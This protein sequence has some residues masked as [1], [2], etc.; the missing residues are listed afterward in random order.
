VRGRVGQQVLLGL[1]PLVL[2]RPLQGG[3]VDLGRLVP[4]EVEL[5]GPG[6]L[7][8]AQRGE[9]VDHVGHVVAGGPQRVEVDAAEAVERLRAGPPGGAGLVRVL[10]VQVHQG[11]AEHG[12]LARVAS[13]PSM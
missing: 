5:P 9:L 11:G 10:A 7:V 3:A 4:H 13:R 12:Q 2:V 1:Q 8:A 6:A